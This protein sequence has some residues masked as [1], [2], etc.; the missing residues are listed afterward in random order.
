MTNARGT[1]LSPQ[2]FLL[3]D[4]WGRSLYE[5]FGERPYLVGSVA[6]ASRDPRDVDIRMLL[7]EGASWLVGGLD[8]SVARLSW[9]L[10]TINMAIT[11]WGRQVTGMPIDFQFQPSDEF[12]SYDEERR[13]ALGLQHLVAND[14]QPTAASCELSEGQERW[15]ERTFTVALD[16]GTY[17]S[18][19]D[20]E[21][22]VYLLRMGGIDARSDT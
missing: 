18:D 21:E 3:L 2:D 14:E 12:H 13:S 20:D 4:S 6:L 19:P 10:R 17:G 1:S 9:R 16:V 15:V 5:A 22:I 7:P 11:L 8:V